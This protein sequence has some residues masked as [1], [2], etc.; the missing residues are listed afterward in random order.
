MAG[1]LQLKANQTE[2][3]TQNKSNLIADRIMIC[4][5]ANAVGLYHLGN[6]ARAGDIEDRPTRV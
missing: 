6:F 1:N 4:Q 5:S 2:K 3:H